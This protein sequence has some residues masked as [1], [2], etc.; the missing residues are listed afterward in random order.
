M[1]FL[2]LLHSTPQ[3]FNL[4]PKESDG[5]HIEDSLARV[6]RCIDGGGTTEADSDSDL[7]VVADSFFV[8]LRCPVSFPFP[9]QICSHINLYARLPNESINLLWSMLL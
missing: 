5:E 6:R 4:I 8:N 7:E 1:G 2:N 9:S 3:I